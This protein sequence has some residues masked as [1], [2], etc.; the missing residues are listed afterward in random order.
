LKIKSGQ[1]R[2]ISGRFRGRRIRTIEGKGTRPM[3]DRVRENL[4]NIISTEISGSRFLD[5]F[6]G[7]GAVGIEALSRS[8]SDVV[9]VES[10]ARWSSLIDVNIQSLHLETVSENIQMDAYRA[11]KMFADDSRKFDIIFVGAPYD[12]DHHNRILSLIV[13]SNVIEADGLIILQYR[14]G[15]NLDLPAGLNADTRNYGITTLA[16]IRMNDDE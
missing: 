5:L 12:E 13:K 14:S 1:L 2:I 6:A 8:A 10:D 9:F 11:I 15:D 3:T 16:F 4:F 7:S